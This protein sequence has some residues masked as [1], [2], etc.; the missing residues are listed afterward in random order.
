MEEDAKWLWTEDEVLTTINQ[1]CKSY[2][3][4]DLGC[5]LDRLQKMTEEQLDELE[6]EVREDLVAQ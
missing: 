2:D 5:M 4:K 1:V 6:A 3:Q